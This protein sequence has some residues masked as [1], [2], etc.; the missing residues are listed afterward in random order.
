MPNEL[1]E[2]QAWYLSN[3]DGDWEHGAGIQIG[4][5]DN[6]GW[7]IRVNLEGTELETANFPPVEENYDHETNW[8]RCWI[9]EG[10]FHG[11]GGPGQLE[12]MLRIFLDWATQS[13]GNA[14]SAS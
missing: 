9:E 11:A 1:R 2:L 8:L 6:P 5:L 7:S 14:S 12:P 13:S 4:T 3:C 10:Q